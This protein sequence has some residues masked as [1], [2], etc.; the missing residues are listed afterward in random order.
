MN[1]SPKY[2]PN[3]E[4]IRKVIN[5]DNCPRAVFTYGDVIH[6]P[7][8]GHIDEC[9]GFHEATHSLQ[10]DKVGGPKNWWNRW[11]TEPHFRLEQELEGYGHQFRKY[12]EIT[13]DRNL[14]AKYLFTLASDLSSAQYGKV[15]TLYEARLKIKRYYAV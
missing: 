12:C 10:Q 2:P 11:L 15:I 14:R 9:V 3:V 13:P 7:S 5:L 1:I 6:N 4:E 8:G